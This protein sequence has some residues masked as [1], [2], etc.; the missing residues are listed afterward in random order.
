VLSDCLV[1]SEKDAIVIV[2]V[3][4]REQSS[5]EKVVVGWKARNCAPIAR[6]LNVR[7]I[8]HGLSTGDKKRTFSSKH[9]RYWRTVSS[10]VNS[11]HGASADWP[12]NHVTSCWHVS[13]GSGF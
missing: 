3:A 13:V 1:V 2:V 12:S 7:R 8:E 5:V 10:P 9:L 6:T 11:H 4:F